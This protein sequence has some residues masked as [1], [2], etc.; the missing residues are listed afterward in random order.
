MSSDSSATRQPTREPFRLPLHWL[1]VLAIMAFCLAMIGVCEAVRRFFPPPPP[2][3]SPQS[4]RAIGDNPF[5]PLPDDGGSP[6]RSP[7]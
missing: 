6:F 7:P 1:G 5:G 2:P 4:C 3:R